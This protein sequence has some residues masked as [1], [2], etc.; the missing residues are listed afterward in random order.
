MKLETVASEKRFTVFILFRGQVV[1][2]PAKIAIN[3]VRGISYRKID[4]I[5]DSRWNLI[6]M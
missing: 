4:I 2:V 6:I 5:V 1:L 3:Y